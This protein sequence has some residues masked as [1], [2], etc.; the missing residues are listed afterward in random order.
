LSNPSLFFQ[1][2]LTERDLK[3][4]YHPDLFDNN[5]DKVIA[6]ESLQKLSA[7]ADLVKNCKTIDK[8]KVYATIGN[9]DVSDIFFCSS[10]DDS[11]NYIVK[12]GKTSKID[13]YLQEEYNVISNINKSLVNTVYSRLFRKTVEIFEFNKELYYVYLYRKLFPLHKILDSSKLNGR[14]IAWIYKRILLSIATMHQLGYI[15]GAVTPDHIL[16]DK[17]DHGINL[18]G[19]LH[20]IKIGQ[21]LKFVSSAYK[22]WYSTK[23]KDIPAYTSIDVF[24]ATKCIQKMITDDVSKKIKGFINGVLNDSEIAIKNEQNIDAFSIYDEWTELLK[25]VYGEPKWVNL[26]LI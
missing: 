20:T 7:L 16:I 18:I 12:K 23:L 22:D 25:S 4:K 21:K 5:T 14:H 15:H 17:E 13:K 1:N 8:Y 19:Q 26:N 6:T 10:Q 24:M 11:Q 3:L 2:G 9:G